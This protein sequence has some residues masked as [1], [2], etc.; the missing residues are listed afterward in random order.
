L[1][2]T[3]KRVFENFGAPLPGCPFVAGLNWMVLPKWWD[4]HNQFNH[5]PDS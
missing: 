2:P 3:N 1:Y 4:S 5:Q